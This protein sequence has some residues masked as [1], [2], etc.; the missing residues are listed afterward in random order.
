M[1]AVE[2]RGKLLK[3]ITMRCDEQLAAA[4]DRE[5][6]ARERASGVPLSRGV[7]ARLLVEEALGLREQPPTRARE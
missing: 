1:I 6:R 7:L 5:Q 4:I 3:T 2:D